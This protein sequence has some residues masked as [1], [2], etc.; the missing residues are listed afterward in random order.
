MRRNIGKALGAVGETQAEATQAST[1]ASEPCKN[2]MHVGVVF[3]LCM[4]VLLLG[5]TIGSGV[6]SSAP[7]RD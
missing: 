5:I 4:S 6:A 1:P 2:R 7:R 3:G